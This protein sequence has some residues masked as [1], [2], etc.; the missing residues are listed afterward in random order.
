MNGW[1]QNILGRE[2]E[3][4]FVSRAKLPK[5]TDGLCQ[6][7]PA[8]IQVNGSAKPWRSLYLVLHELIHARMQDLDEDAVEDLAAILRTGIGRLLTRWNEQ[9]P[10]RKR[11][12]HEEAK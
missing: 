2:W 7:E 3:V 8:T 1:K 10:E 6:Y 4:R 9:W 12:K 11:S 5:N